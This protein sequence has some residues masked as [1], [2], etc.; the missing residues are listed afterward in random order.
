M[1]KRRLQEIRTGKWQN[2]GLSP[3]PVAPAHAPYAGFTLGPTYL[4]TACFVSQ[5]G[6]PTNVNSKHH[7]LPAKE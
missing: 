2:W 1:R 3:G 6:R 5:A 7:E 4:A